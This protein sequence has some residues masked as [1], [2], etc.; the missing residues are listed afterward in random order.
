MLYSTYYSMSSR[1]H[2]DLTLCP[3]ASQ[4]V[5]AS[6]LLAAIHSISRSTHGM[7]DHAPG[8][9]LSMLLDTITCLVVVPSVCVCWQALLCAVS[10]VSMKERKEQINFCTTDQIELRD[11]PNFTDGKRP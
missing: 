10:I 2:R 5:V 11:H 1:T 4:Q 6:V 7:S 3:S 9:Y 8:S